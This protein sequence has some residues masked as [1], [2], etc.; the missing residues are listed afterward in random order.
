MG[1]IKI[2]DAEEQDR[3][4]EAR[5]VSRASRLPSAD[6]N[7]LVK[8]NV[9][10]LLWPAPTIKA[11]PFARQLRRIDQK[12]G[13]RFPFTQRP[14]VRRRAKLGASML[15]AAELITVLQMFLTPPTYALG[16]ADALL[17]PA[18]QSMA[19]RVK[20]DADQKA[21]T[22]NAGYVPSTPES[23][24]TPGPQITATISEVAAGGVTVSDP[25]LKTDFTLQPQF[26]LL[27][28]KQVDNRIIYPLSSRKGW[29]VY[30]LHSTS[31]KEDV[32]LT[33]APGDELSLEYTMELN[34]GTEAR[35]ERDGS[36]GIYGNSLLAGDV[37]TGSEKDAEL[38]KKARARSEKNTLLFTIPAPVVLEAGKKKSVATSSFQLDGNTLKV[39][40]KG[41]KQASYPLTIDPSIYV[42]TAEKFMRGNN[43]TNVDFNVADTLIQKG[44]TTGAR[45]DALSA[46]TA[47]PQAR[48]GQGTAVAGGY[49]Y[50]VGGNNGTSNQASLYWAKFNT[51]TS[52]I[53][54]P[55][56]GNG[57]CSG[58]CTN[59]AYNLP[60]A[61]SN[62][63][64]VTYNGYLYALGG[65]DA[66][67][68][69]ANGTG[70][71]GVCSTVYVAKI[72]ANGE[73]QLWH[74]T[75]T[76]E[77]NWTYWYR[78]TDLSSPRSYAAAVASNNY[79]YLLGGKTD[80]DAGGVTTVEY[81]DLRPTG[82]LTAW[83]STGMTALPSARFG[84][85][86]HAYNDYLYLVG[87]NSSGT[88]TNTINYIKINDDGTLAGS[89]SNTNAFKIPRMS[90]GGNFSTIWGGYL[91][92]SG[93]CTAV[94]AEGQC[95]STG[96]SN[97]GTYQT[98]GSGTAVEL[99]SINADGSIAFWGSINNVTNTR[100]GYSLVAWRNTIYAIG[101]CTAQDTTTGT[102]TTVSTASNYGLVNGDGDGSTVATSTASGSSTC[103]GGDPYNCNLPGA[104]YIGNMLSATA[105]MNGHLYIIG[106]C[107]ANDCSTASGNTAY[108][109]IG[110]DGQLRR[111]A[112][113]SGTIV[114]SFCV[115][116]V[117]PIS[118]GVAAAGTAIFGGR[119][120]VIGGQTSAGLK[121]NIYHVEINNDG[122]LEG[123]W[124]TQSF[125]SIGATS[126][127][128]TYAYA[129]ANPVSAGTSPGNLYIFG[130]C[131]TGSGVN[132]TA[133]AVTQNVFKCNVDNFGTV[134]ACST[135]GQLQ[136]GT[137]P[138]ASG[139]GLGLH[140]GTVYAGYI[141]LVGGSA[142]GA[143]SLSTVRYAK[144]D[145]NNNVVAA[146]GSSWV[147]PLDSSGNPVAMSTS[148]LRGT[149]FG[150]NGYL[151]AIGGYDAS[152][153]GVLSDIQFAKINVSNGSLEQ[154]DI[155]TVTIN[156]RWGLSVPVS[157]SYAYIIGGCTAGN[158]PSC[159]T[160]TD[161]IQTF[162]IYNNDSG[163]PADYSSSANLFPVDRFGASANV[164]NGY[165]YIAGGC[166]GD[167]DCNNA[168]NTVEYAPLNPDGSIG[169]W[170]TTTSLPADRVYGQLETAG[171]TLYYIG[172]Q[173]DT[174]AA[175]STIYYATPGS[176][177][178]IASWSVATGGVGDTAGGGAVARTQ[179][180]AT[181][182]NNRIYV[183]G[184][185][186]A[187]NNP[188]NTVFVSPQLN[189]GG[190][191]PADS[192]TG[193]TAFNV[194][195]NG[196]T[197]IA[198][199][200]NLY[201]L[202]GHDGL[203][204]LSDVQ[205]TQIN[206]DG[207]LDGWS[208]TASLP[209]NVSHADGFAANGYMYIFGGRQTDILCTTNTYVAP[210]SANTSV[211]SG[212][213]PTGLG[214]WFLTNERFSAER[215]AHS[216]VYYEG[217]AYLL[218]GACGTLEGGGGIVILEDDFDPGIDAA[219]WANTDRMSVGTGCGTIVSGNSLNSTGNQ[220]GTLAQAQTID[221][222]VGYGG[223]VSFYLR[224]PTSGGAACDPPEDGEDVQLQYSTNGGSGWTAIATYDES[225]FN[226]A[227]LITENIPSN[228]WSGNT[229]F[230]WIIPNGSNGQDE[231]AIDSVTITARDTPP[232]EQLMFDDIDPTRDNTQWSGITNMV[233][234]TT[235][236][237]LSSGNALVSQ[238]GGSAQAVTNN[239]NLRYGGVVSFYL[240]IPTDSGAAC[241]QPLS[242]QDLLLQY[243]NNNGGNWTT[244]ATYDESN[245]ATATLIS[246]AIPNSAFSTT[247]RFRWIIPNAAADAVWAIDDV[248]VEAFEPI[249]TYTGIHRAVSTS[250]LSQPQVAKYS[251]M[252]D[253]DSDVF[254]STWLLNGVDNS[255]GAKWR[256]TYR[257][258]TDT[259][260]SCTTPAMTTWGQ[261]TNFGDVTLGL[262]GIY[263]PKDGSGASTNCSRFYNFAV[264]VDSSK[265]Y[266]YPEDISRGPTITDLTL[267]FTA[268]PSKRLMHG[269]TF[270]GGLQQ[271]ID[272]PYYS[273]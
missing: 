244:F 248:K 272:T 125:A 35:K 181:V 242:G 189:S 138:G 48:W 80:S 113:C 151:Y 167:L 5:S 219:D 246:T 78:D 76:N 53:D 140:A 249:L 65:E 72:G 204:F 26:N 61:R 176:G 129:R 265:A 213:N 221:V 179:F 188:M 172:G 171:G 226:T 247:V 52:T 174:K 127:S 164:N 136:I 217:K 271:P 2:R 15:V 47:L 155:S 51:N 74:P 203:N 33:E 227:T 70:A 107:T 256:L 224:I 260:T 163:A 82:T 209:R 137:V 199:A 215:S 37:S 21:Y 45:F 143:T 20:Y 98:D 41:L 91:Y 13:V 17:A 59:S 131:T 186:D 243:S 132:C 43:E 66:T 130:G 211:A 38:L 75:D 255:I 258:M 208:Y 198:Y 149:A 158:S 57:T 16:Q 228:A 233:D 12:L 109:A 192:W 97:G 50:A 3:R 62:L 92:I 269:R 85:G 31:V 254:P 55:N 238:G 145:D 218:G 241:R 250:L 49:V 239:H 182:W 128:Y 263:T 187:S 160:R 60:A 67:C 108:A 121:G 124:T 253:T 268:D 117:D 262:P 202:G 168:A 266:G 95:T 216:A 29:L 236:G 64:V 54:S 270:T 115:D 162:Q 88:L 144:F 264:T 273:Q 232:L 195:R 42:E 191:I 261:D 11:L 161:T 46:T 106:G 159:S 196:V 86:A 87:G 44:E 134:S 25:A 237:T 6:K 104:S 120:Y 135:T 154:F 105:V 175:Q 146:N 111:P 206:A 173:D 148:R 235:C 63:S 39:V 229:R 165:I 101:G 69:G 96:I 183:A 100:I 103:I 222:D 185:Y 56:P 10:T 190:D 133:G 24:Q 184:G 27:Q 4:Y 22:F 177:G 94:D 142:P 19:Q 114:D 197:A 156:Q 259:T 23:I 118:G 169:T 126:V 123:A 110:S 112:S 180:G 267:Q 84:H 40:T 79:L 71:N 234:S 251:I 166:I 34:E 99:A 139:A 116:N 147:E 32:I 89:W 28:G 68:I 225:N 152:G 73:P 231:F 119:I 1:N 18:S 83:T 58:W 178:A 153:G 207:T 214:E 93:G 77:N 210:I 122:T 194:P 30:S 14:G 201:I 257:S 150:Y 141:Y 200:N 240:R 36:I 220:G 223:T 102:C 90:W 193:V 7:P 230:R 212:N 9:K 205:Y 245:Y 81:A 252:F 8:L 157:N 170:S